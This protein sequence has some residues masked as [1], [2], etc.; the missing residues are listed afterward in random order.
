M[1]K[2][3]EAALPDGRAVKF[4]TD[5]EKYKD[6]KLPQPTGKEE[7]PRKKVD[8]ENVEVPKTAIK[9]MAIERGVYRKL[10]KPGDV[11]WIDSD[12]QYSPRWMRKVE[13]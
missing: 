7:P 13:G 2:I 11:F 1:V 8:G 9:V 12:E 5:A 3:E 4:H 6:G 10:R